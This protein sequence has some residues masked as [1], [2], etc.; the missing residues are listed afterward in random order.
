MGKPVSIIAGYFNDPKTH[1]AYLSMLAVDPEYRGKKLASSLLSEFE[2]Y[3]SQNRMYIVKL[4]V[5][6][7]ND[8]AQLLYKKFGYKMIGNASDTSFYMEKILEKNSGGGYIQIPLK[9]R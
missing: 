2:E 5:R 1:T 4:E 7:H 6:K 9:S 8:V 3:A